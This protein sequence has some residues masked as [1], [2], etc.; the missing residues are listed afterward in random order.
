MDADSHKYRKVAGMVL[1]AA[2]LG[3]A[4]VTAVVGIEVFAAL[5]QPLL[6]FRNPSPD[7]VRFGNARPALLYVVLGDS[8]AAGQGAT[9]GHGI[10]E[11]TAE[12]LARGR[13]VTLVNLGVSGARMADVLSQEVPKA[14]AL[15]PDLVLIAAGANDSTHFT[16]SSAV[17]RDFESIIIRLQRANPA[18]AIVATG[19]P[20]MGSI[21]RFAQPLR[22][23][24]GT[25]TARIN[26]ALLPVMRRHG[27]VF[28]DIAGSTGPAFANDPTL[29]A[30]D[31]FHPTDRGYKLWI[32]V[33]N[34]ALDRATEHSHPLLVRASR[35]R[36]SDG[37]K[38]E[39]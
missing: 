38:K 8:T 15:K 19:C 20:E 1:K 32:A 29:F 30:A 18:M 3:V 28:A 37:D 27:V 12:Y 34:R 7:R 10:A 17:T 14:T 25:Q 39:S 24:A 11:G 35:Q 36:Q 16:A 26:R 9:Q 13:T 22:W 31:L 6:P 23:I 33:L 21:P 5:R 4:G 2:I